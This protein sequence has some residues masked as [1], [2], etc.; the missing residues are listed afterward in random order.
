MVPNEPGTM[1]RVLTIPI[2]ID[3][4]IG[5]SG[6]ALTRRPYFRY[7]IAFDRQPP[8]DEW[9][10]EFE[11][12]WSDD[13]SLKVRLINSVLQTIEAVE[14][15]PAA[16]AEI[17]NYKQASSGVPS[18]IPHSFARMLYFSAVTIT[19]VGYGDIVPITDR[20]RTLCAAE[21]TLGTVL[22]G[23]FVGACANAAQKINTNCGNGGSGAE[24]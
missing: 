20:A 3:R 14:L 2:I 12:Q 7:G 15:E 13:P 24:N 5:V 1:T 4:G 8:R 22:L 10:P 18:G 17:E 11:S 19:T 9:M 23:L 16:L 21:A 6:D